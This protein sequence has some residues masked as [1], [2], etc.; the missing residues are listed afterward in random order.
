MGLLISGCMAGNSLAQDVGNGDTG[1]MQTQLKTLNVNIADLK[2]LSEEL[3]SAERMDQ[4]VLIYRQDVRSF[5]VLA[6]FDLL[7]AK[8]A[9][10]P[11]GSPLKEEIEASLKELDE[12]VGNAIFNRIDEIRQRIIQAHTELDDLSGG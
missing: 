2:F 12:G 1:D 11:D 5:R 9:N 10:L 7:V 3:A 6:N 4:K 8:L